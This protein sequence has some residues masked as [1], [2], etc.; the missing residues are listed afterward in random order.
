MKIHVPLLLL[1]SL[2]LCSCGGKPSD[3][4]STNQEDPITSEKSDTSVSHKRG[5]IE[6]IYTNEGVHDSHFNIV[7]MVSDRKN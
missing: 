3:T 4:E 1:I 7:S 5:Y 6:D 2:M